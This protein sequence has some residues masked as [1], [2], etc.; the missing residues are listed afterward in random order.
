MLTPTEGVIL[1][2]RPDVDMV[3]ASEVH[4]AER[5]LIPQEAYVFSGTMLDNLVY[6][7]QGEV[8]RGELEKACFALGLEELISRVGG[9]EASFDASELSAGERQLVALARAWLSP[10]RVVVLDEATCHLDAAAEAKAERAFAE[11]GGTLVVIAHRISSAR[12]ADRILVLDGTRARAGPHEELLRSSPLY[13][14]LCGH[15]SRESAQLGQASGPS[16]VR[17]GRD[18]RGSEPAGV[19]GDAD[20]VDAVAGTGLADDA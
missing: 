4:P 3:A 1:L 2:G 9:L 18:G 6:L 12:R 13:R 11:R 19:L 17:A 8:P 16:I 15:W 20:G 5:A 10:A 14:D 7:R